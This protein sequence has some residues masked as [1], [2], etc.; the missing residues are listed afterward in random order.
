MNW[1]P[2]S[3]EGVAIPSQVIEISRSFPELA[4][5]EAKLKAEL[6][7]HSGPVKDICQELLNAGG[8]R[9]RPLLAC[10]S[11]RLFQAEQE[12]VVTCAS[13]IELIH[14]ASLIHDDVI[15]NSDTRRGM[16]SVNAAWG[17]HAAVLTG[18]FLFAKAFELLSASHLLP[19][20]KQIVDAVSS[21]CHGE[22]E[23]SL[24]KGNLTQ[25]EAQ[26]LE[27]I[28]KKTG[29]LI[30]ASCTVGARLKGADPIK[31][32]SL[33]NYGKCLGYGFQIIDDVLD[34][35][36]DSQ[37]LGKPVGLDLSQG[38]ITLPLIKLL[39]HP[40]YNSRIKNLLHKFPLTN[41]HIEEIIAALH[42]SGAI[43]KAKQQAKAF[44]EL[45]KEQLGVFQP[46]AEV[47]ALALLADKVLDRIQ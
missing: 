27:R 30:A 37:S 44:I 19:I 26:Y 31:L 29:K 18:D 23:Q 33:E 5:V 2:S 17:N 47:T 36:G 12:D 45:A 38:N 4:L 1:L 39:E 3:V 13:A 9:L 14:M 34:F 7:N 25:S 6:S 15:D 10:I 35:S 32:V 11:G 41:E 40:T 16:P 22:I 28:N 20:L 21:M 24:A 43:E 42:E 46:S 8:K